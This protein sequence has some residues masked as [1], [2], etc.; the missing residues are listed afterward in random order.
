MSTHFFTDIEHL[1]EVVTELY[2]LAPKWKSVG[3]ALHLRPDVLNQIESDHYNVN[4]CLRETILL[5]LKRYYHTD[6][7]GPP[8]W[9]LLVAAVGHPAGGND[10][11]LAALI[12]EKHNR[13]HNSSFN[14]A[15]TCI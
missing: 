10:P 9:K 8:S 4:D 3:L 13:E 2:N 15:C 5:W 6:R 14:H 12:A 11:A 7:F 1:L